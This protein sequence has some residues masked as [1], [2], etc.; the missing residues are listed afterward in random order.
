[1]SILMRLKSILEVHL[2]VSGTYT[3]LKSVVTLLRRPYFI[4]ACLFLIWW[5]QNGRRRALYGQE[6]LLPLAN[7]SIMVEL[8]IVSKTCY[9]YKCDV[10]HI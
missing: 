10:C 1:M 8:N 9:R 6:P 2:H 5:S 3:K 7:Y 4:L